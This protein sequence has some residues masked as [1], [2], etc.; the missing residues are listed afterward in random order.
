LNRRLQS[1]YEHPLQRFAKRYRGLIRD[2]KESEVTCPICEASESWPIAGKLEPEVA[3]WR[4]EAGATRPYTWRLCMRC[5]NGYPSEPP[6]PAVLDRYWQIDRRVDGDPA[7]VEAVWQRRVGFS[8]VG[9][10]RSFSV[11]APLHRGAPGR[12]LDI[13]CGLG[14]TI[15]KF[16]DNGWLAEGV[17]LD[18]NT[19]RFHEMHGLQ[20]RIGRFE[21][22][23]FANRYKM[24]QISHAIYFIS[25]PMA[26]LRR[27]RSH[28]TDDGV[29]GVVISDFLASH[30]QGG[31]G[32]AHSFYP[33]CES[34]HYALALAGFEPILTRTISGDIYIAIRPGIVRPP[35]INTRRIHRRYQTQALRFAT[36]GRPYLAA[37]SLVKCLLSGSAARRASARRPFQSATPRS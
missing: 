29:F 10:E 8:R 15:R 7:T 19:R 37:R 11:F 34:M 18:A 2:P 32:Y 3:L 6:L 9:A 36:I 23:S 4:S 30:S 16:R 25:S 21:D 13:A 12:F 35:R 31:P 1:V 5:G 27:V 28:L 26:F 17:D 20:V 33:C 24:I 22:M 14:E